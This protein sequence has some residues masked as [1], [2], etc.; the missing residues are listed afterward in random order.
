MTG[1]DH[2][3]G[4]TKTHVGRWNKMSQYNEKCTLESYALGMLMTSMT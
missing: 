3:C 1:R 2:E 4:L